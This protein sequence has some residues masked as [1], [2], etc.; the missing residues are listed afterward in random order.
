MINRANC[1]IFEAGDIFFVTAGELYFFKI[2]KLPS[3]NYGILV[4]K[5]TLW[6]PDDRV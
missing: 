6:S 2:R 3:N 4:V 5:K 1:H